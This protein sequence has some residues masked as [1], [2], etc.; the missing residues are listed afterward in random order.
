VQVERYKAR[1]DDLT[2]AIS[3]IY[4]TY[5]SPDGPRQVNASHQVVGKTTIEAKETTG[6][7]L[8]LLET[9]FSELQ[10]EIEK[11]LYRSIYPRFVKHQITTSAAR[12]LPSQRGKYEG[13]GDCFCLTDPTKADNPILY[14]SDGFVQVTGYARSDFIPRNCRFLQG[15]DTDKDARQRLKIAIQGGEESVELL[16]N[17]KKN[18]VPF[19][20]LLYVAPL[21]NADGKIALFLGGQINCSTTIHGSSDIIRVLAVS[22]DPESEI[23]ISSTASSKSSDGGLHGKK[24]FFRSLR[25]NSASSDTKTRE[26]GA[27][28]AL[29][30]HIEN[31]NMSFQ[32]Q[33]D[34]FYTAYSKVRMSRLSNNHVRL[35][36]WGYKLTQK[37]VPCTQCKQPCYSILL[38]RSSG[39]P[40]IGH[41]LGDA[42]S[43]ARC[44]QSPE[45]ALSDDGQDIQTHGQRCP[46]IRQA[47]I[48]R[49]QHTD[50]KTFHRA[51]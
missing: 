2:R 12:A 18:G 40:H 41:C 11:L 30:R 38:A 28:P 24:G 26:T 36:A 14:A 10:N 31:E 51:S 45:R 6:T 37:P 17:Y 22:E 39:C 1:L 5:I 50:A 9:L 8:P 15:S 32:S 48:G 25:N 19:W 21:F 33:V 20:N 43:W 4:N 42:N 3:D 23:D 46:A 49:Y 13:L 7:I 16:L 44:L 35:F 29:L 47:S 27:E 34:E